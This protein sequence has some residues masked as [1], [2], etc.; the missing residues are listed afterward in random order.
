MSRSGRDRGAAAVEFALLMPL[1]LV[2]LLG[3]MEFGYA[4]FVQA[5]SPVL[6]G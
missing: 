4:F 2:L 6:Q 1:L 5:W 3:I